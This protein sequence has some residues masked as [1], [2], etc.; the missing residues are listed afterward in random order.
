[1]KN[2][3]SGPQSHNR[4]GEIQVVRDLVLLADFAHA[5]RPMAVQPQERSVIQGQFD[6]CNEGHKHCRKKTEKS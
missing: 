1:M 6:F 3:E 5:L 2:A 4:D